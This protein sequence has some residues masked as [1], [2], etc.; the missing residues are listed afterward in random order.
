MLRSKWVLGTLIGLLVLAAVVLVFAQIYKSYWP[1]RITIAAGGDDTSFAESLADILKDVNPPIHLKVV[2][3]SSEEI[4]AAMQKEQIDLAIMQLDG[5]SIPQTRVVTLIYPELFFLVVPKESDIQSPADLVG[6][7]VATREEQAFDIVLN[8]YGIPKDQVEIRELSS[9][10]ALVAFINREIDATFR[11][12][13]PNS[14]RVQDLV[15]EGQGRVI[16]F[17]QFESMRLTTPYLIEYVLP[18]GVNHAGNPVVPPSDIK[19]VGSYKALVANA[20]VNRATIR[21]LTQAIFEHQNTLVADFPLAVYIRSPLTTQ[22]VGPYVHL[23]AQAYY[24]KDKPT[25]FQKY[26]NEVSFVFSAGPLL[27][28][29]LFALW[30]KMR[31]K[32]QNRARLH[33]QAVHNAIVRLTETQDGQSTDVVEQRLV[34]ILAQFTKD[35]N[36]GNI[37]S[38]DAQTFSL[39]WD[40]AIAMARDRKKLVNVPVQ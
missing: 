28:S 4:P 39:I 22:M 12:S 38:D 9:D 2:P 16:P 7:V 24:D 27:A 30:A 25:F 1:Q 13:E 14:D 18:R 11:W 36:D 10:E 37:N 34:K 33:I 15:K 26:E 32:Q 29:V 20:K 6:K 23:G 40:R 8:Y 3:I 21:T 31:S 5:N 19:M 17:D 35:L